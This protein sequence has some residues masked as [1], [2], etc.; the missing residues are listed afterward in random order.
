MDKNISHASG[1]PQ[2]RE[3]IRD[4]V[5]RDTLIIG[6]FATMSILLPNGITSGD[7]ASH[8]GGIALGISIGWVVK[9]YI[10]FKQL[11]GACNVESTTE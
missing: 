9:S 1:L 4:M 5:I 2:S 3:A 6:A 8:I 10:S 11:A 7:F